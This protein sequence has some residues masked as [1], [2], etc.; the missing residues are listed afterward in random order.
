MRGALEKGKVDYITFTSASTVHGFVGRLGL[1]AIRRGVPPARVA[2]IGPETSQA[3]RSEGLEVDLEADPH[4]IP[5][6]VDALV[7]DASS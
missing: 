6:L 4:S 2:A 3:A 7:R 5:G 1:D